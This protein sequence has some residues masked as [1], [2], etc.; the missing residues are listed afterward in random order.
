M[1]SQ[2][3]SKRRVGGNPVV[4]NTVGDRDLIFLAALMTSLR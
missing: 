1:C 2:V 3:P 4:S